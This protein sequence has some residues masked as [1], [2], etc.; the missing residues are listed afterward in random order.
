MFDE[1]KFEYDVSTVV[2]VRPSTLIAIVFCVGVNFLRIFIREKFR[3]WRK[4][5]KEEKENKLKQ[6]NNETELLNNEC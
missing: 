6:K 2:L 4:R 5:R 1:K 3:A